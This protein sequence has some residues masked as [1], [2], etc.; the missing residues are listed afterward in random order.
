MRFQ[1]WD[2]QRILRRSSMQLRSNAL[3]HWLRCWQNDGKALLVDSETRSMDWDGV[4]Q[5]EKE[6]VS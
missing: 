4:S 3:N 6:P 5:N 2:V 1:N